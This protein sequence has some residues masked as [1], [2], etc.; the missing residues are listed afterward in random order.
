MVLKLLQPQTKTGAEIKSLYEG[1]S[2]TNAFTD[3]EKTKLSG[4]ETNATADQTKSDIDALGIEATTAATLATARN[5]GGVSFDGSANIDLPG[6]NTAGNQNTTGS[7][8]TLTTARNIAGVAFDGSANISLNN[9]AIT[10]GA[11]YIDGSALN[12]A[13]L[14]SGTIP[15]ARFP[16]TLPAASAANLTSIPAANITGTLPAIDGSNLT[17]LSGGLVGGGSEALFVEAENQMD[18]SY[19]TT[20]GKNYISAGP[21]TIASSVVLTITSGSVMAFV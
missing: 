7:A 2:D 18:T 13:N 4:I 15:D 9:N 8:A 20:A 19:T 5:I 10:N 11:G 17:G 21:L 14:S 12:A 16:A 3:A 1:E 6:V